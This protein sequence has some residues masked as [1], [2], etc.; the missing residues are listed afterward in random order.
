MTLTL[1]LGRLSP[2]PQALPYRHHEAQ[3]VQ[4]ITDAP[5]AVITLGLP[6]DASTQTAFSKPLDLHWDAD[7]T[8]EAARKAADIIDFHAHNAPLQLI[9]EVP[10]NLA[11]APT[12]L[13]GGGAALIIKVVY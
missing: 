12:F 2:G 4:A 13:N 11:M 7:W 3:N 10:W 8:R 9:R 6:P 5:V 1:L